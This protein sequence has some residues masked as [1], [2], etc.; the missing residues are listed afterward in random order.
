MED[1]VRTTIEAHLSVIRGTLDIIR[2]ENVA[3]ES[4]RDPEFRRRV[5]REMSSIRDEIVRIQEV[6]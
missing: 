1:S 2:S 6:I 3:L 5:E 4:E